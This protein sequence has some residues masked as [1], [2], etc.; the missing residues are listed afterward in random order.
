MRTVAVI[1]LILGA[2]A[3]VD[4]ND[5]QINERMEVKQ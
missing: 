5:R 1:L 4:F 2:Y 3:A